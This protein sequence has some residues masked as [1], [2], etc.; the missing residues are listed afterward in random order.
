M[1]TLTQTAP[2]S[3]SIARSV[4]R[5]LP[6][7]ARLLLGLAFL[8]FGL[9]G[10]LNFLPAPTEAMPEAAMAFFGG[11]MKTGYMF[12]LIKGTEVAVGLA[13]VTNRL[14]PLA[15]VVLAPVMVNILL[16]HAFLV[17]S[18]TGIVLVLLALTLYLAWVHRAAYRP[19]FAFRT[20]R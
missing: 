5:H 7:A 1:T 19:L 14:V 17:S 10:F 12:P 3:F 15:L 13:L 16:V 2:V 18:G 11:L 20:A 6:T 4:A 8:V 9:N